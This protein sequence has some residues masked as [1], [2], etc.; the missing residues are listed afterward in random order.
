MAKI[1]VEK[2]L[3]KSKLSKK[4]QCHHPPLRKGLDKSEVDTFE[5]HMLNK[6]T[7]SVK[8][9][10]GDAYFAVLSIFSMLVKL[11]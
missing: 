7:Q 8:L 6:R 11:S 3:T 5:L 2:Q 4:S 9:E 10:S 1:G